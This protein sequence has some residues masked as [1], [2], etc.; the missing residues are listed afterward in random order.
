MH[1]FRPIDGGDDLVLAPLD[2]RGAVGVLEDPDLDL[3]RPELVP[4]ATVGAYSVLVHQF[5]FLFFFCFCQNYCS[6]LLPALGA[7][8]GAPV[9]APRSCCTFVVRSAMCASCSMTW[10]ACTA[11]ATPSGGPSRTMSPFCP[12]LISQLVSS[13]IM[14]II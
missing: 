2:L 5:P 14:L 7:A 10:M 3:Q 4:P 1:L 6:P 8:C 13:A 9:S 11:L 12:T